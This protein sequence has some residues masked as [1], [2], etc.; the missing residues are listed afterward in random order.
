MIIKTRKYQLPKKVYIKMG[1][2]NIIREQW[3]VFAIYL[4]I[5]SGHF[6]IPSHWWIT[7]A[8]IALVLYFL[9]WLIQFAGVSQLEQGKMMFEKLSY[10]IDSRQILIKLNPKQGMP[11]KWEMIKRA[12]IGKDHFMLAVNKAQIIYLPFKIFSSDA[13]LKW[14]ETILNR[15]GYIKEKTPKA[16]AK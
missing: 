3:W 2:I 11:I 6:I 4:A 12:A 13:H 5:V 16:I 1:L 14:M 8:S 10:E 15:K 7:G 9:F